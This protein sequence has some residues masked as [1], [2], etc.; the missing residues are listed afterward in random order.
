MKKNIVSAL[1]KTWIFDLDGT[2]VKHNGYK[3]DGHDTML[4][5]AREFLD[6]IPAG[7]MIV[8]ITSRKPDTEHFIKDLGVRYDAV[9]FNAP[10]GERI[11]VNDAKPSGLKTAVAINTVRDEFMA[12]RFEVDESL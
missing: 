3:L 4:D 11:L 6:S 2:I 12:D 5:G 7:D 1:G 10:Y 9:I 8:F